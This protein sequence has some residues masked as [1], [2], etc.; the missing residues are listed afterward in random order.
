MSV[1]TSKQL[2]PAGTEVAHTTILE[3]T[4]VSAYYKRYWTQVKLAKR[5][6]GKKRS[7][8]EPTIKTDRDQ[9]HVWQRYMKLNREELVDQLL[10]L[11]RQYAQL[12]ERWLNLNDHVLEWQLRAEQAERRF[13]Q[14]QQIPV[15]VWPHP[16][17]T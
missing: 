12:N 11:E 7:G 13:E 17:Q 6:A 10:L 4:E 2:D 9:A 3:H 8:T 15:D 16:G 1:A 5:F 14:R